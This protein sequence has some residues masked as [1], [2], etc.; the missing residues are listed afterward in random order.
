MFP[1]APNS[2]IYTYTLLLDNYNYFY[3]DFLDRIKKGKPFYSTSYHV[4]VYYCNS[5][6]EAFK[7]IYLATTSSSYFKAY[8]PRITIAVVKQI[9]SMPLSITEII[10]KSKDKIENADLMLQCLNPAKDTTVV[11]LQQ[12]DSLNCSAPGS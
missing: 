2:S 4:D 8:V 11:N 7:D 1:A 10:Q 3:R 5:L 6:P 12:N 9:Q